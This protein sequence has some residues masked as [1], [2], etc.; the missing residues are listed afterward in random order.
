MS[1]AANVSTP[2]PASRTPEAVAL[3]IAS[4]GP[5]MGIEIPKSAPTSVN[6]EKASTENRQPDNKVQ[7]PVDQK[8]QDKPVQQPIVEGTPKPIDGKTVQPGD[9][10]TPSGEKVDD[11]KKDA[12]VVDE[13]NVRLFMGLKKPEPETIESLKKQ[14]SESSKEAKRLNE[15]SKLKDHLLSEV[16][17]KIVPKADGSYGVQA[18]DAKVAEKMKTVAPEVM[19]SL[20][21]EERKVVAD[22]VAQKIIEKTIAAVTVKSPRSTVSQDDVLLPDRDIQDCFAEVAGEKTPEGQRVFQGI[23]D[24]SFVAF[25]QECFSAPELEPFRIVANRSKENMTQ[26]LKLV[27]GSVYRGYA[28]ILA[29]KADLEAQKKLKEDEIKKEPTTIPSGSTPVDA[30]IAGGNTPEGV[31]LRIAK[32]G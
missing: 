3:R 9:G 27:H 4:S 20:S 25:M 28:P 23:E 10:K 8:T 17:L 32:S 6:T 14:R 26:F 30:K 5:D 16:D 7:A 19:E 2:D 24:D 29:K 21:E 31:A 13:A 11:G 12:P 15:L 18:D 22:D 1:T